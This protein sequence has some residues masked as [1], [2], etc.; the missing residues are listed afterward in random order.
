MLERI[1]TPDGLVALV[2]PLLRGA[3]VPHL[4]STRIG[5]RLGEC[6]ITAV[7]GRAMERL[8]HVLGCPGH[9]VIGAHQVHGATVHAY[10]AAEVDAGG[11]EASA[12]APRRAVRAD[13]LVTSSARTLLAVRTADCV[14]LLVA[15]ARGEHVAAVHAG[16]RGVLAGVVPAALA[17]LR[18]RGT[19]VYAA[20][21]PSI[22][23]ERFEVGG[24]VA[25]RF[26]RAGL[27]ACVRQR[28]GRP[29][30]DLRDAVQRQLV[31]AR[32]ADACIDATDLC[33]HRDEQTCFSYRRDVTHRGGARTGH[34]V[35]VIATSR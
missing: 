14:P 8:R 29:H 10:D 3:G 13:A 26:V 32:I 27:G 33:T 9:R 28:G 11:P 6:D 31:A 20:I 4:F 30:V 2:S 17:A 16:W 5:G 18:R 7:D 15:D 34:M 21:G 19:P 24:D 12:A 22:G 23:A 1:T 25:E 35:A